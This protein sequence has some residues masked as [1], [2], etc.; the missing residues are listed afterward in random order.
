MK[1]VKNVSRQ[2]LE[3]IFRKSGQWEHR[4]LEAG[5]K[6]VVSASQI[7]DTVKTLA[8]RRLIEIREN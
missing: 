4:W 6:V 3:L 2:G 5:D 8:A 1:V 7:T